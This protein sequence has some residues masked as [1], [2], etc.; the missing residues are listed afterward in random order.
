MMRVLVVAALGFVVLATAEDAFEIRV[1]TARETKTPI[2]LDGKLDEPGWRHAPVVSG[3]T[4]WNKP[5]KVNP[6]TFMRITYD[7]RNLYFGIVCDEPE[8]AKLNPSTKARDTL[9]VF[10]GEAME[11]FVDPEHSHT[12]YYQFGIN[13]AGSVYDSR[14]QDP[15]WNSS[16]RVRTRHEADSWTLE[17]AIPWKDL[18]IVPAPG[19]IVGFNA[20]RDRLLG[21]KQWSNWSQTRGGFHDPVRFAHLLLSPSPDRV[22]SLGEEL[23]KGGRTGPI[24]I[25]T[26]EGFAQTT[27]RALAAE[28][29]ARFRKR[30]ADLNAISEKEPNPAAGKRLA[31]LVDG[32]RR[33]IQP[34]VKRLSRDE[35]LDAR[36]WTRIDLE[37]TELAATLEEAVWK[38]RLEAL[39]S[40]L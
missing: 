22:G 31:A 32:L 37:T 36:E 30:L 8:M 7:E 19:M 28:S 12:Q 21:G 10:H 20:C 23:R 2:Q 24:V 6:Q 40:E 33:Q 13:A 16:I 15:M 34:F 3:F 5:V 29:V 17:T 18:G 39:L 26:E 1:Y 25:F 14:G 9:D 35:A 11:L 38:A 27:Y 4:F